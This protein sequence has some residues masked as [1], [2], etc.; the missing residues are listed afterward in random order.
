M[1]M[2]AACFDADGKIADYLTLADKVWEPGDGTEVRQ[3]PSGYNPSR[4]LLLET[5]PC[6]HADVYVY[7]IANTFPVSAVIK[8]SPPFEIE[9]LTSADGGELRT[10]TYKINQWGGISV[11]QSLTE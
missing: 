10:T 5:P 3:A 4:P 9:L 11:K 1:Y 8:E 2:T 6:D 7:V